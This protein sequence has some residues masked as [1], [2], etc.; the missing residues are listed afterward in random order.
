MSN[1]LSITLQ[2]VR[3][4]YEGSIPLDRENWVQNRIDAAVRELLA[5]IP[6]IPARIADQSL[7][8]DFVKDKVVDAVL[9]IV[10]GPEGFLQ[11]NEGEYGYQRNPRVASGDLWFPPE[12]L[13]QLGWIDPTNAKPR[14][15]YSTPS[16]FGFPA[17]YR[18]IW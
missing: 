10:R 9:R 18:G 8:A 15:V 3:D 1:A 17:N 7:D 4:A 5:V 16:K 13:V 12:D 14:S 11:E 2:D 6:K